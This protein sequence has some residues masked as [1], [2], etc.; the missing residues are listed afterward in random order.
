MAYYH[1]SVCGKPCDKTYAKVFQSGKREDNLLCKACWEKQRKDAADLAKG[2][3]YLFVHLVL[4]IVGICAIF[5]GCGF[6]LALVREKFGLT[7]SGKTNFYIHFGTAMVLSFPLVVKV[8]KTLTK[9][10]SALGLFMQVLLC[11]VCPPLIV[12]PVMQLLCKLFRRNKSSG[13]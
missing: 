1:C 3:G 2:I 11:V 6:A 5:V 13:K 4:P 12:F 10:W 8:C 7:L 9:I